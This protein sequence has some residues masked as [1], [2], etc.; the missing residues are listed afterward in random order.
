MAIRVLHLTDTHFSVGRA[1]VSPPKTFADAVKA[2]SGRTTDAAARLVAAHAM[3]S[4]KPDLVLHTGDIVDEPISES[5]S[6]ARE[7]LQGFGAPLLIT[8]GN[9]DDDSIATQAG[10]DTRGVAMTDLGKWRIV[11][12]CS[13]KAGQ[14]HGTF[15][16]E[17]LEALDRALAVDRP[18]LI[19]THHPP[20]S[21]CSEFDCNVSDAAAFF[22]V[23]DRHAN[24]VAVA[25]GHLHH[26]EELRRG[27]VR[28]LLGPSTCLQLVHKHPL[29]DHTK[30]ATPL[31]ARSIELGDDGSLSSELLWVPIGANAS[32]SD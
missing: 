2:L 3:R 6:A 23:I 30:A 7:V 24:V 9:H 19:G 29:K 32:R 28:Y 21:T 12:V 18:V 14:D 1:P 16:K 11:V 20:M 27:N 10:L 25:T 13:A 15:G 22:E 4:M 5:Y 8:A 17:N 26:A 31:G